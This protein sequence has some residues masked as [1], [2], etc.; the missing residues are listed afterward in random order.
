MKNRIDK[1]Y[2]YEV[3][4][5]ANDASVIQG[6][7]YRFTVLTDRLIRL[8]YNED[9]VFEDRATQVVVNRYFE[10]PDFK[11]RETDEKLQ[12][13]TDYFKL[14]YYKGERF[15][16]N[17]LYIKKYDG[18]KTYSGNDWRYGVKNASNLKGTI[19]TLDMA[20]GEVELEDGLMSTS[21]LTQ[22]DD[23]N[24]L[25]I[26]EDGWVDR[27]TENSIDIYVF[28]YS[29][30][31]LG[32]LKDFY[33]LTGK[34][35]LL[36]RYALGN[37]WSRY[38]KYTQ[39]EYLELMDRFAKEQCPFSVAVIDM[40]WH[41]TDCDVFGW[42]G[43]T[44]NKELFP[45]YKEF[46]KELHK[47]G[48]EVTLNLHPADG[49]AAH[50]EMYPEMAEAMGID[51]NSGE[52]IEFDAA[53]PR[54][55]ENYFKIL[56]HPYEK[57]GVTFW[58]MDWQQ[59]NVSRIKGLDPLWALNHYHAVDME[60]SGKRPL[61]LSRYAGIGSHRYPIGFSGDTVINWE[62]FD[63]QP[64]FTSTASNVGYTWWSH[65]I[66]GH[67][68]GYRDD[69]LSA[70]WV[71]FGV[72]SPINRL[73]S[74]QNPLLGKE[75]WNFNEIAEKSMKRFLVL[76]H[77]LIP[78]LYTMNYRTSEFGEPLV[79]PMYYR[80]DLGIFYGKEYRN[81]YY[82]G[83]EMF[84]APITHKA[85][86][87][88]T[89]GSTEAYIPEGTWF[90][91]F[92]GRRYEGNKKIRLYRNLQEFP[93]FVKAGG[94]I[95]MAEPKT[96]NDISNPENLR[97]EIYPG[98]DNTFEL[99]E[100]DG[101]TNNYKHGAYAVTKME[102][103]WSEKCFKVCTPEGDRSVI[104]DKRNYTLVFNN[105]TDVEDITVLADGKEVECDIDT[106][107]TKTVIQINY[108]WNTVEVRFNNEIDIIKNNSKNEI[109]EMIKRC[110]CKNDLKN[111]MYNIIMGDDS[112][113][114][115]LYFLQN[116]NMDDNIRN[117]VI[118]FLMASEGI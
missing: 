107:G 69:E 93:V 35:P 91:F 32:L 106:Y 64:Y 12:I 44:W 85:D 20:S 113:L 117:A 19:R 112:L 96:I 82:F 3:T 68:S 79:Q 115:I 78:Y 89:M 10:K 27:H 116:K 92:N 57:D 73:H 80:N 88:T 100:D 109:V 81:Q 1:R 52:T 110:Q 25:I 118:E 41:I 9:G 62:T 11:V 14:T 29:R 24:S 13:I 22:I 97:I 70:R 15:T 66:G 18:K 102:W 31:Y 71:Q 28:A 43:Y 8:E 72:F 45:D 47:R 38:Y 94:I 40:D 61:M 7:K 21:A 42:T 74:T 67:T 103:Q 75:P 111:E 99:Y 105:I 98:A 59:E 84:V 108:V 60:K 83:T 48:L 6:E 101:K 63:F 34:C 17:N 37:M 86:S 51:K 50:E 30:D 54:F 65:D 55:W 36:P 16:E 76:R 5:K 87:S 95:P 56:H 58:W 104:P 49:I 77:K 4:P 2:I 114:K 26:A 53:N 23:S 39:D 33:K 90:D 46:L